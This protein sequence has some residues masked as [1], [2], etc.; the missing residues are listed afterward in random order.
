[1]SGKGAKGLSGKGAKGAKGLTGD[2]KKPISRSLKAGLQFPVGRIH[3][4]L[5]ARRCGPC[6]SLELTARPRPSR[7]PRRAAAWA[8]PPPCTALPSWVRA[9]RGA[10]GGKRLRKARSDSRRLR[11]RPRRAEYLTAEV[12]ELA[13]NASKDLKARRRGGLPRPPSRLPR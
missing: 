1:M 10:R 5:K 4:F 12:L 11:L 9:R 6:L 8:P 2:K 3:R 13:G 7:A